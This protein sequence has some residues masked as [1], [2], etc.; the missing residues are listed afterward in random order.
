MSEPRIVPHPQLPHLLADSSQQPLDIAEFIVGHCSSG[1]LAVNIAFLVGR[2]RQ[3]EAA[4]KSG[5]LTREVIDT[6]CPNHS[7]TSCHDGKRI[8]GLYGTRLI[9]RC[10]RCGLLDSLDSW[11]DLAE[12]KLRLRVEFE[13]LP[14]ERD[15][16]CPNC[17]RSIVEPSHKF[18]PHCGMKL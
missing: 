6:I 2:L 10:V 9:P 7:R 3:A 13:P 1:A 14:R 17:K 8:N 16:L 15:E 11:A 12:H 5:K 18:C 4:S